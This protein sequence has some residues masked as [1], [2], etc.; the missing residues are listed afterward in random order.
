[1][2]SLRSVVVT[3]ALAAALCFVPSSSEAMVIRGDVSAHLLPNAGPSGLFTLDVYFGHRFFREFEAGG[4]AG[5]AIFTIGGPSFGIP[6]D[7]Y[8]RLTFGRRLK[9]FLEASGGPWIIAS[10]SLPVLV[11]HAEFGI[12]LGSGG[13]TFGPFIGWLSPGATTVG[14]RMSFLL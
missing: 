8:A 12:G 6:L 13:V 2:R 14:L 1:M 4:R 3:S 11:G 10:P 7:L 5:F 9:F